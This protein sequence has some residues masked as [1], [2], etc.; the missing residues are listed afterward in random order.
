LIGD[1]FSPHRRLNIQSPV[2][3][4]RIPLSCLFTVFG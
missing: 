4:G 2:G 1:C 3:K